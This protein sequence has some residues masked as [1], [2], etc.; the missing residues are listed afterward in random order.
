MVPGD[1]ST[2]SISL[3]NLS[4]WVGVGEAK[5]HSG[6][7]VPRA[8]VA[9]PRLGWGCKQ[10]CFGVDETRKRGGCRAGKTAQLTPERLGHGMVGLY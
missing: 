1:K 2:E 9:V 8:L 3:R 10:G 4:L 6:Q 7:V 5:Y